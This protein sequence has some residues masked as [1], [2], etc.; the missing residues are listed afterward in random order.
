VAA[1]ASNGIKAT[2]HSSSRVIHREVAP[3]TALTT[4]S[5][6]SFLPQAAYSHATM[7]PSDGFGI[8][9]LCPW[10]LPHQLHPCLCQESLKVLI[11]PVQSLD[12][13]RLDLLLLS[14]PSQHAA[15][16]HLLQ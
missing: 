10:V 8:T 13:K 11:S 6:I 2:W 12:Q 9:L 7:S 16:T 4:E 5:S 3:M 1:V 14:S 15:G